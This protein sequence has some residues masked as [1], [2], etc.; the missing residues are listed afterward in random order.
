MNLV[1][2][3]TEEVCDGAAFRHLS[4]P[5]MLYRLEEQSRRMAAYRSS[6]RDA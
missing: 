4:P 5:E 1:R 2:Q 3:L 6:H